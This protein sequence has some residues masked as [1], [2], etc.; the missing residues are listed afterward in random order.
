MASQIVVI[1]TILSVVVTLLFLISPLAVFA[2]QSRRRLT[3][4]ALAAILFV[5]FFMLALWLGIVVY[6]ELGA[7]FFLLSIVSPL[8]VLISGKLQKELWKRYNV[9][10]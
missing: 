1:E 8:F 9:D 4:R 2:L 3:I 10:W 6:W 5:N 7:I